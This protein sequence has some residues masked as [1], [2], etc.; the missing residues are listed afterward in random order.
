MSSDL[1][2]AHPVPSR[3]RDGPEVP[4][5]GPNMEAYKKAHAESVGPHA[6]KWWAKVRNHVRLLELGAEVRCR[7]PA[8]LFTGIFP[9]TP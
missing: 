7:W 8:R 2:S 1:A 9:S 6:D 3:L 4:F 5:I